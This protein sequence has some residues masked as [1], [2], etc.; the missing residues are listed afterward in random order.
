[1]FVSY[2][3]DAREDLLQLGGHT[4]PTGQVRPNIKHCIA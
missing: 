4:S 1:M 3:L 2:K